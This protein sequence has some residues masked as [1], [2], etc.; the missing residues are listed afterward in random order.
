MDADFY[1]A[2]M[3]DGERADKII[4]LTLKGLNQMKGE[5]IKLHNTKLGTNHMIA[6][7]IR[8]TKAVIVEVLDV[9]GVTSNFY[10]EEGLSAV[11]SGVGEADFIMFCLELPVNGGGAELQGSPR[12]VRRRE[13]TGPHLP[14]LSRARTSPRDR[15]PT[16]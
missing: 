1:E 3:E 11:V 2:G 10:Q 15:R 8:S 9:H 16:R 14:C 13:G 12:E 7:E 6:D 4:Q 5:S